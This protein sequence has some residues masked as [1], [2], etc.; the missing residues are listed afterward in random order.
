[1]PRDWCVTPENFR[2]ATHDVNDAQTRGLPL[3]L[4]RWGRSGTTSL[5]VG[6][7]GQ[8]RKS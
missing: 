3:S 2:H 4:R 6:R 8:A 1:V 7:S 5:W